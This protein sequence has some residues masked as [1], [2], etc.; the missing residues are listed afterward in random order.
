MKRP[1]RLTI[2]KT[3][4]TVMTLSWW[5]FLPPMGY[6]AGDPDILHHLAYIFSHANIWHLA[7]NLFVLWMLRQDIHLIP[8]L[9]VAVA[10]SY[11]PAWSI[12]GELGTTIGMSGVLFAIAGIRWGL[13]D[14]PFSVFAVKALPFVMIGFFIPNINWCIHLYSLVSGYIYGRCRRQQ[15]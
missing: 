14:K 13:C 4:M 5:L 15:R 11:L 3:A 7:G 12:Y 1:T 6:A 9:A 8:S 2:E 10:A